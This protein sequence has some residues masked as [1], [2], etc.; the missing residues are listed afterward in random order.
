MELSHLLPLALLVVPVGWGIYGY[1]KSRPV[2]KP[3]SISHARSSPWPLIINSAVLY[4][5]SF[6]L[7]FFI[8]ELFLALGKKWLGLKA[9][10][11]HNNHSWEGSHP[12]ER[13]AQGYGALAILITGMICWFIARRMKRSS[14]WI[15]LFFLWMSFEGL[16]QSIPQFIT[17]KMAPDTDTGQ[18][19]TYLGIGN[20]TGY[21]ICIAG[22]ISMLMIG[23][24]FS[25]YLLQLAP[26]V[27]Y[28]DDAA[29]RF[30]YLFKIAV[31]AS[32]AGIVL[33]IPF[34]IMPWKQVMAPIMVTLISVPMIFANAWRVKA[35]NPVNNDVNK[36]IYVL[37]VLTLIIVL[38]IFQFVLAKGV[39]V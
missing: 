25:R 3:L 39:E 31:L 37:P 33:I 30:G 14:H 11:Y 22:I 8:Q 36:K 23:A 24:S 16:S 15:Q 10:L 5:L 4:A 2:N 20:T 28:T 26:S 12:M 7:I 18:A 32:L 27:N 13:L 35:V 29:K 21:F 6:N 9:F 38:I 34:R 19:F 1:F 17:A